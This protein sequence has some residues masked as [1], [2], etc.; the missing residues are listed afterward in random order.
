M[1]AIQLQTTQRERSQQMRAIIKILEADEYFMKMVKPCI[2]FEN[3]SINWDQIFKFS[4]S[5]GHRAAV[6][7]IY[8]LWT[9]EIRPRSNLFD[10]A[11]SMSPILQHAT[12]EALAI[13]WGLE[14]DS[15]RTK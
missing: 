8:S 14:V 3:E 15:G 10:A 13:R 4:W 2:D 9:D 1:E 12:L 5:S 7:F 6:L 11:L